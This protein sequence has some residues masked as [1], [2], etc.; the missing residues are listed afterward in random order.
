[1]IRFKDAAGKWKRRPAARGANGRVKPGHALVDGKALAVQD[2]AYE[3]RHFVNRQPVYIPAG[4]MAAE[5]DAK[6]VRLE[7]TSAAI[8]AAK[9]TDVQVISKP[10]RRTLKETA[11]AYISDAEGRNAHEAAAQAR[12]ATAEFIAHEEKEKGIRR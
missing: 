9:G 3:L 5:A 7:K 1:M 6:R 8:E 10:G 11:N 4:K 2:G 12:N